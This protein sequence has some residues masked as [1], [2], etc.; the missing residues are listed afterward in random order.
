MEAT[1]RESK[2][3]GPGRWTA[4]E[5][6]AIAD[7][8]DA[9]SISYLALNEE[10]DGFQCYECRPDTPEEIKEKELRAKR[11]SRETRKRELRQLSDMEAKVAAL[12]AKHGVP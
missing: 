5:L 4:D 10:Y 12:K 7:K 11:E 9:A 6:R 8:M 1:E 2:L 3:L